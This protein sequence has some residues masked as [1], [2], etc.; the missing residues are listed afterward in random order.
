VTPE[1]IDELLA[2]LADNYDLP[3][4]AERRKE[5]EYQRD[6]TRIPMKD[7]WEAADILRFAD[8]AEA[9]SQLR[10]APTV[11]SNDVQG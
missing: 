4:S 6:C 5:L 1:Q 7:N 9:I 3:L 8:C 11:R 2:E 10:G